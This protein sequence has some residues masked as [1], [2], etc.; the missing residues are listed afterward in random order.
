LEYSLQFKDSYLILLDSLA[1]LTKGFGVETLKSIFPFSFVNENNLDYRGEVPEL[2][3][4]VNKISKQEYQDYKSRFNSF[5]DLR[6]ETIKYCEIYCISL[7]QVIFKFNN[8]IFDLF[9]KNVHHYPTLPSLALGIFKSNFMEKENIPQL[10][11]KIADDIRSGYTGGAT[12]MYIPKSKSGVKLKSLDVNSLYP[13]QMESR[14]MPIGTPTYFEGDIRKIVQNPFGFFYCEI[15]A[16]DDIKHPILQTHVKTDNGIR[17]IAPIGNWNEMM[18]SEELYNALN[19]G[20]QFKILWGYTFEKDNIFKDYV[21]FLY[22]LRSKYPKSDPMNFI[23]KILLNSL[24]GRFG[25]SDIFDEVSI[26]HKDYYNEFENKFFNNIKKTTEIDDYIMVEFENI[27]NIEST[28]DVSIGVAAAITAYSRIHMSIFKNNPKINL[29][30][31]DTDSIY[32]D[33]DSDI[34]KNLI[35]EKVLG[36]LKIENTYK[37][38]IFICAKVYCLQDES[39]NIIYKVKGLKHEVELTMEDFEQLLNK[40]SLIKKSQRKLRKFLNQGHIEVLEQIYTLQVTDNKR[41]LIYDN[42]KLIATEAY[43]INK[44]KNLKDSINLPH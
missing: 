6:E 18:F 35:D 27:E 22:E 13:S 1:K 8:M 32:V 34:D 12:D 3:Y 11:G 25:M 36:K 26:I 29:Y 42:N 40:D 7:Y 41:K 20:Y 14:L 4:F 33:E 37:K 38:G 24:Y 21:N 23:A 17:T 16:R 15:I 39:D 31:T 19:Y 5:W 28:P 9:G 44:S 10:A 2:K 43:K 30:Y